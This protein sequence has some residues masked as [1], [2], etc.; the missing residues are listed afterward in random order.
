MAQRKGYRKLSFITDIRGIKNAIGE[1]KGKGHPHQPKL[2]TGHVP[3]DDEPVLDEKWF[4][5]SIEQKVETHP[6]NAMEYPFAGERIFDKL[7]VGFVR[8]DDP[9]S[10]ARSSGHLARN[11][12]LAGW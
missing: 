10:W 2:N 3:A 4:R 12:W 1:M 8:G 9:S 7:L 6:L 11:G 5:D